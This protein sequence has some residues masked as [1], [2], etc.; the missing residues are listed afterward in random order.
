MTPDA[1]VIGAGANGLVAAH[2]LARAGRRVLVL[3]QRGESDGAL[4]AG[5]V[6]PAVIRDLALDRH[7]LQVVRPDPWIS[8]ALPGGDRLELWQ[9]VTRTAE[10]IRRVS[11]ADATKWPAFCRRMHRLAGFLEALYAVPAPDVETRDLREL[12]GL[13]GLGLKARRLGKEAIVDLL[14][15]LPM[16]A[17][18]LLDDWFEHDALKAALGAAGVLHLRQGPRAAG[19]AFVMLHHHVGSLAGVFRPPLSNI[20]AVLATLPGVE[21]RR[22]GGAQ[23][24]RISVANGRATGV[25]LASGEEIRASVIASSA[26]PRATLLGLLEPGWLDPEFARAVHSIKCRG[27]VGRVLLT[28]ARDPGFRSL[29]VAPS[30]EYLERAYDD[31]KYGVV[32]RQPYL[33]ARTE[34]GRVLVHVQYVPYALADGGWDDARRRALGDLVVERLAEHA[35][36]LGQAVTGREV[37][38]PRDLADREGL[39]E[40]N[41]YHGELTLDQVLFMRPVPGWSRYRTPVPGLYLCGSG[42]HPGGGI[43]GAA[44]RL[45]ARQIL[46]EVAG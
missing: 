31:A 11:P 29:A 15:V 7:G 2:T 34:N 27:V 21:V 18:E 38:T 37:L 20:V 28:V 23:V 39:T 6:P 9:D 33:E 19:T 43:A 8:V 30:L 24:A 40:G 3:E 22:G 44:G 16:S 17:G 1:I 41:A 12:L 45:A 35:P 5:W 36:A 4:D 13:A 25:V 10:A 42:A 26:D 46:K 32:S 14:R